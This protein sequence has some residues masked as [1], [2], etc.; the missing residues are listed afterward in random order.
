MDRETL[1]KIMSGQKDDSVM[2]AVIKAN[3]TAVES[4]YK[5]EQGS[6]KALNETESEKQMRLEKVKKEITEKV[7]G[8]NKNSGRQSIENDRFGGLTENIN[9]S[10]YNLI[11]NSPS[12]VDI[13]DISAL[14]SG[15]RDIIKSKKLQ[16]QKNNYDDID[17]LMED[18]NKKEISF[19]NESSLPSKEQSLTE[20]E[21]KSLI[22]ETV[23]DVVLNEALNRERVNTLVKQV[24]NEQIGSIIKKYMNTIITEQ[25]KTIK[26]ELLTLLKE[27]KSKK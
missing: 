14:L 7:M 23:Y 11:P 1:A 27:M 8:N 18:F 19:N 4:E 17:K 13:D 24:I 10:K 6:K 3:L 16:E 5:G 26:L 22:K 15:N 2:K 20:G 9:M 12:N 25:K 21:I